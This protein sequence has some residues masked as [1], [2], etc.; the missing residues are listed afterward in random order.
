M[1]KTPNGPAVAGAIRFNNRNNKQRLKVVVIDIIVSSIGRL[2]I[3]L[4]RLFKTSLSDKLCVHVTA[5]A[6]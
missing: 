4:K 1:A 3:S 5:N 6:I 2:I